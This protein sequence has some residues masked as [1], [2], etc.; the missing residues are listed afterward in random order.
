[1]ALSNNLFAHQV[2]PFKSANIFV[3]KDGE[4]PSFEASAQTYMDAR[5][6][7][8]KRSVAQNSL[9]A[10]TA[11]KTKGDTESQPFIYALLQEMGGSE[12]SAEEI[13]REIGEQP[14]YYAQM[15]VLTKK[16]YQR[17]EFYSDLYDKPA[18]VLRKDVAIQAATLMQKRDLYQSYLRSEMTLAVMLE[19]LLVKEQ[20]AVKNDMGGMK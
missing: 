6:L 1:M 4:T 20:N 9:S 8:A 13:K 19:T 15:D 16:L 12:I 17:P 14:S 2:M 10:I 11:L 3:Q 5:A 7:M 18:N